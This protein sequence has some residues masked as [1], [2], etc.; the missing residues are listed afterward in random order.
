MNRSCLA[1]STNLHEQ[2]QHASSIRTVKNNFAGMKNWFLLIAALFV[3]NVN[4]QNFLITFN[5]SGASTTVTTVKVENLTAGTTLT[6][7]GTDILQLT[8]AV[9][10]PSIENDQSTGIKIYPN[11]SSDN[12]L[13]VFSPPSEGE[14]N[15]A[16]YEM[17]GRKV[18]QKNSSVE[19]S[20]QEFRISGLKN[21][22]YLVNVNGD[23]YNFSGKLLSTRESEGTITIEKVPGNRLAVN[24][25][26]TTM[27]T[28]GTQ[29]T[30]TM[31]YT[32]GDLLK[33]TCISGNYSTI[34]TDIPTVDKTLEI[35]FVACADG[36]NN[37]YP[38]VTIGTQIW[39]AENLRTTRTATGS[40][41][42]SGIADYNNTPA[43]SLIYGKLYTWSA[44][45]YYAGSSNASPSGVIGICPAG[46][47]IP[48]YAEWDI[49]VNTLGG[50]NFAGGKLKETGSGHWSAP[51][52]G[53]SN[54]TGFNGTAGGFM[55]A[56]LNFGNLGSNGYYW[57]ST[58]YFA[59]NAYQAGLVYN[60]AILSVA[61]FY[62]T[63]GFS[64][65][66]V[67]D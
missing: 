24:E 23:K 34:I 27:K 36:D 43:N 7:N 30:V 37:Y 41:I 56:A 52:T 14:V 46:W 29:S 4:G 44:A 11:P 33:Y 31:A 28:K 8:G 58:E 20:R 16:I 57:S 40:R 13:I 1:K 5:G 15:I 25:E 3:L 6:L 22:L 17:T 47:H 62:K 26:K 9:A 21:G 19:Q 54:S 64:C 42:N 38:V 63:F 39:M 49:L 55:G 12:S 59:N 67:K 51:N 66:C 60:N 53:A 10:V 61:S 18:F 65:R 35:N 50:A 45:M 2:N 48:S 32:T